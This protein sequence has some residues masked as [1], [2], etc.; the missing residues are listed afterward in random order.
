MFWIII[1]IY[2]LVVISSFTRISSSER[3]YF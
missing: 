1:F 3:F 2:Y